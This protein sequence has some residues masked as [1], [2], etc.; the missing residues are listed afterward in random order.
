MWHE[1]LSAGGETVLHTWRHFGIDL[2]AS[3]T[4]LFEPFERLREHL[5]RAIRH[6]AVQLV[7]AQRTFVMQLVKHQERPFVPELIYHIPNWTSQ[8]AWVYFLIYFAHNDIHN[9]GIY[10][11]ISILPNCLL[12]NKIV[13]S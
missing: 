13:Y 7:E 3:Q 5:L 12:Y 8:V 2:S 9:L 1:G 10:L 4:Y 11:F 6:L